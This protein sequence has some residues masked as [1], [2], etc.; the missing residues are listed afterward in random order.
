MFIVTPYALI[1]KFASHF[2]EQDYLTAYFVMLH[3]LFM[4]LTE[5][6][7]LPS[8]INTNALK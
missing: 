8:S 4:T 6:V 5:L 1:A 7:K 3:A 2:I